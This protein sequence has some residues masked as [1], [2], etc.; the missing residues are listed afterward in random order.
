MIRN[1]ATDNWITLLFLFLVAILVLLN[2]LFSIKFK[3]FILLF[4]KE[5]FYVK[6]YKTF[7]KTDL[8]FLFSSLFTVLV[9]V[10]VIY[11]VFLYFNKPVEINTF[12]LYLRIFGIT[13]WYVIIR[14]FLGLVIG[15]IFKINSYQDSFL[16][17]KWLYLSKNAL[18]IFPFIIVFH[19]YN[20]SFGFV[21]LA[22]I[23]AIILV[24][25]YFVLLSKNQKI[26]FKHLFYFILY[27]CTL[28]IAP[29]II[30][31]KIVFGV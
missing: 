21:V 7:V 24:Y 11:K 4:K 5:Q 10:F 29:L 31:L 18:L 22:A 16:Y 8:F 28:E 17:Y 30:Y 20:F 12:L 6:Y 15:N 2:Y 9:Y 13:F 25:N 23:L 27:L 14:Y 3:D 26:I 19:Y 1:L